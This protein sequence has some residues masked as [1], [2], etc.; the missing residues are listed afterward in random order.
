MALNLPSMFDTQYA[1]DR[2]MET[3]A[4]EA[5]RAMGGG[6]RGGMYYNSSL[7]GDM[8]GQG[9]MALSGMMGGSPDPR[10][11]KQQAIAEIQQR[12]PNP[13]TYEEFMELYNA[14]RLGGY[15]DYAEQAI[16]AA[17]DVRSSEPTTGNK[18]DITNT[19]KDLRDIAKNLLQCDLKDPACY[20]KANQ[21]LIDRKRKTSA[22]FGSDRQALGQAD[23]LLNE[24]ENVYKLSDLAETQLAT[25]DQSIAML[26][27]GLW[28]GV[29]GDFVTYG[30]Q[31]ASTFGF[32][33]P[34]W[35]AGAE[36]FKVNTMKAVMS[37]ISQTKGAISEKEMKL[38]ADA[39]PGLG[40]TEA[41]N[42][43]ILNTM[44]E[45]ALFQRRLE[46]EYNDWIRAT[47]DPTLIKWR[48]HRRNW[49][50]TNG[51]KAPTAA[52]IKAALSDTKL[53]PKVS[54]DTEIIIEVVE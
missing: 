17:N 46:D 1:M 29:G 4:M 12:F 50:K 10:I 7:G 24:Q 8:Y 32:S 36:Q 3:D 5:A 33:E 44:R 53:P 49:T 21:E 54:D 38:F 9:L 52:E 51:I 42:R 23:A 22:E 37:W 14:L 13:D 47:L 26:N 45:A 35:A 41:G 25:I 18:Y 15:Y 16:K 48:A 39:A 30:K 40:K 34:D 19:M 2:Q 27:E 20:K 31:L 28:T 43:L 11:A 6:K